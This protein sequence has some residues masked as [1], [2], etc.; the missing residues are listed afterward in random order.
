M[1]LSNIVLNHP[2][3]Y[4]RNFQR[5]K[6]E[7]LILVIEDRFGLIN[8]RYKKKN[9]VCYKQILAKNRGRV[10]ILFP[11]QWLIKSGSPFWLLDS[12]STWD[13]PKNK[14][15]NATCQASNVSTSKQHPH[16]TACV[17][18][19]TCADDVFLRDINVNS[20]YTN[21]IQLIPRF[22]YIPYRC[23]TAFLSCVSQNH[24]KPEE[25]CKRFLSWVSPF[26]VHTTTLLR[27]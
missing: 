14:E 20:D 1:L 9:Q 22:P 16:G 4:E 5:L 25:Q 21:A 15:Q 8:F 2:C 17:S 6:T 10:F 19:K 24:M 18:W 13:K 7:S 3:S 26:F 11:S 12:N 27:A 23:S